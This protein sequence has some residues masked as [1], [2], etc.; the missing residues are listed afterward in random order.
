MSPDLKGATLWLIHLFRDCLAESQIQNVSELFIDYRTT[1]NIF[2]FL[3]SQRCCLLTAGSQNVVIFKRNIDKA[4]YA[5][6][7]ISICIPF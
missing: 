7:N 4:H 6:L 2:L 3:H 5:M 1:S